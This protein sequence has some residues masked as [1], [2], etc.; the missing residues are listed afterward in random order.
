MQV[1]GGRHRDIRQGH[2]GEYAAG[3]GEYIYSV[4]RSGR[5]EQALPFGGQ[6]DSAAGCG[7]KLPGRG[8]YR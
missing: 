1:W 8:G 4:Y 7:G 3:Y 2:G 6:Q 5:R